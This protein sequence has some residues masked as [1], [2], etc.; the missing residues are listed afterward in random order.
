MQECFP[1]CYNRIKSHRS[2]RGMKQVVQDFRAGTTSVIDVPVPQL[3]PNMALVRNSASL[4]SVGTERALVAFASKNILGKARSRPD[5]VR[6]VVD[7][8]RREGILTTI[9]AVRTRLDQPLPLGYS[10]AGTI[11]QVGPGLAD[12]QVGD[13]VACAGGGH[14]VHAEYVLVPKNLLAKIPENVD[15]EAAAFTTLGSIALHGFRL[16]NPT[17]GEFVAV[18]GLG[19]LGL[20]AGGVA[21]AAGCKVF[22]ID[23]DP[24]RV[25]FAQQLGF[26]S[27]ARDE[28]E[29]AALGFTKGMGFDVVQICADTT[30]DDTVILAG[31]ITRDR[32]RLI[33]TGVVGIGLPRK[34]YFEK[35]L[36]FIVSRSYGPGRYDK[37]YEEEGVDYPIGYV[38]WTEQRNLSA[39][40]EILATEAFDVHPLI[41]HRFP[42]ERA[43]EAYALLSSEKAEPFL[44]V[45]IAYPGSEA[46]VEPL[47][48][49]IV[50][51]TTTA[52]G[53]DEVR[54]GVIG[55]GNFAKA[56]MLPIM[57]GSGVQ[58]VGLTAATGISATETA[59]RFGFEYAATESDEILA[60][61]RVNAVAIL[62]R[63]DLHAPLVLQALKADKHVFCEKPL[64]I[65]P[66]D[67]RSIAKALEGSDRILAVG[68]NRRFAPY[69]AELK[70]FLLSVNEP[71]IMNYRVNAG[72]LPQDH[73]LHDPAQ[74]GG[75]I[76]GEGCHFI[77]FLS[78]VASSPIK[79]IMAKGTPS[80]DRY[81]EDNVILMFKYQNGSVGTITYVANGDRSLPKERLEVFGGGS[82]AILDDFRRLELISDG[83]KSVRKNRWR[84]DKGH[85]PEWEAFMRAVREGGPPPIPYQE[86]FDVSLASILALDALRSGSEIQFEPMSQP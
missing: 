37:N 8:A 62:T 75:R 64:A 72:L 55:A 25:A 7:K 19:V 78:F 13:R 28:A 35:E 16:A 52:D 5:L 79:S 59:K 30:E 71:L 69:A 34:T 47:A 36:S 66:D 80:D 76:I 58:R 61:D 54:L 24:D 48:R 53:S 33:S 23:V 63:H 44:G 77:D 51:S 29:S 12:F 49:K 81:R 10:S 60:D 20:L 65:V 21:R 27:V 46:D 6:Q 15:F 31:E 86:L 45:V 3:K 83:R 41:S 26:A 1:E 50:L 11:V 73:W 2:E 68:F 14:A 85:R 42:I 22:G 67:L 9:D 38:R 56:V 82:V 4:V 40:L 17:L 70:K 57:Q 32:G 84:Q 74:G 43:E 39:F 18:I